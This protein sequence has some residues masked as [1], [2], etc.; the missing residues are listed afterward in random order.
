VA[1]ILAFLV[2]VWR[3]F[4]VAASAVDGFS[5][6]LA[7]GLTAALGLQAFL[8]I[9]GVTRLVPLTGVTLPF[10]SYGGSSVVTNFGLIALLLVVSQRSRMQSR[11]PR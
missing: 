5:K 10:M 7:G 8:I 9:G 3:G 11:P 6:L 2:L 1:V 4:A